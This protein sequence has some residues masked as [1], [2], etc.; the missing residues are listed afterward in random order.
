[1]LSKILVPLC[2]GPEADPAAMYNAARPILPVGQ[3]EQ[4]M[5]LPE[6]SVRL[7]PNSVAP[8]DLGLLLAQQSRYREAYLYLRPWAVAAPD[9]S[10]ARLVAALCAV[11]LKRPNEA[12]ELLSDL[13]QS[14]PRVRLLWGKLLLDKADPYGALATLKPLAENPPPQMELDVRRTLADAHAAVGQSAEAVKLLQGWVGESPAVALQLAQVQYQSGD[15][16]GATKTLEPFAEILLAQLP[17]AGSEIG[18]GPPVSLIVEYGRFLATG[19]RHAD[20]LPYLEAA[21]RLDPSNKQSWHQLG[22]AYAAT[23]RVEEAQ[24]ALA[25]FQEIVKQEV[26]A[27]MKEV[28]LEKNLEDPTGRELRDAMKLQADGRTDEA[29]ALLRQEMELTPDDPRPVLLESRFLLFDQRLEEALAAAERAMQMA[30]SPDAFYQRGTVLLAMQQVGEAEA[31]FR[32][33]LELMPEH[34]ATLND[35]AVLLMGL[36]RNDEARQMLERALEIRPDDALA[37]ANLES[38]GQPLDCGSYHSCCQGWPLS[39]PQLDNRSS[40]GRPLRIGTWCSATV[41]AAQGDAS[42]RRRRRAVSSS[43]ISIR[44]EMLMSCSSTVG[45]CPATRGR[46]PGR[47]CSGTMAPACSS[48]SP[49]ARVSPS[50]TTVLAAPRVTSTATAIPTCT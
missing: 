16:E 34:T 37:A 5:A 33:A 13:D 23:G 50:T 44:M 45:L 49:I 39:S 18:A 17:P 20:A 2:E 47:G 10:E 12:E 1:M 22:Q 15:L 3:P 21:T 9:D 8:R 6:R 19:G 4:A 11:Q 26:P 28:E 27:A 25:K 35:Y 46:R 24:S 14:N 29:L 32:Q 48:T 42:C 41:M 36:G 40:S 30:P 38:L 31:S 7:I 43:S